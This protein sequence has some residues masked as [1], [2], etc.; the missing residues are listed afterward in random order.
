MQQKNIIIALFLSAL[1]YIG[2]AYNGLVKRGIVEL[3]IGVIVNYLYYY[4][5]SILGIITFIWWVYV[6]YD[7]YRCT[8]A[9][10]NNQPIPLFL[11]LI[12]L[13]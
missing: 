8:N 1:F 7:T 2:N 12:D 9:I 10:N 13:E 3:V 4:V 6:L 5:S 11:E